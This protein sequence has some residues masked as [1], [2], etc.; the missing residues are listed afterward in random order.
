MTTRPVRIA[1]CS[2]WLHDRFSGLRDALAGPIDVVTG[3]YL[4]SRRCASS[5]ATA[6]GTRHR[7]TPAVS[8]PSP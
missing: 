5:H 8:S 2:G 7:G 4:A 6:P 1:N 3:D